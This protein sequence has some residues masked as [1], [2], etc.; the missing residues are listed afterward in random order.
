[1]RFIIDVYLMADK[2][3][4]PSTA[5][6]VMRELVTFVHIHAWVTDEAVINYVYASTTE[7]SP[8]RTF[9]RDWWLFSADQSWAEG[10]RPDRKL[11]LEFLQDLIIEMARLR[12]KLGQGSDPI[13]T[14]GRAC[15]VKKYLQKVEQVQ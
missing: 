8:L 6:V 15:D 11:P 12:K 3:L 13:G 5:N 14:L 7:N 4:D 2:S 10:S 9:V 1:V